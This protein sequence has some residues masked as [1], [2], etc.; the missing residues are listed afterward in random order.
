MLKTLLASTALLLAAPAAFAQSIMIEEAY[1]RVMGKTAKA[2][3]AFMVIHN[4]GDHEDRLLSASTPAAE[5]TELHTHSED[6]SGV[7]KMLH[8]PEGFA[9]A[10]QGSHALARGGDHVMLMGLTAPLAEGDTFP[11]ELTFERAGRVMVD[12]PVRNADPAE[13][14]AKDHAHH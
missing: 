12:V 8:V 9:I 6:A 3:S 13:A 1:A 2:G 4:H 11:L 10:A 7:M 5:R 14:P